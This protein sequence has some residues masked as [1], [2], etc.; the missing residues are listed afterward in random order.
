MHAQAEGVPF[1][2]E[3]LA[4]AYRESGLIQQIDGV[5]TLARERRAA[6]AVRGADAD[7]APRRAPAR[8]DDGAPRRRRDPRPRFSLK[9][10]REVELRVGRRRGTRA[11][12][13]RRR[14]LAPAVAAGLLLE[15]ARG[16]RPPTTA[17]RTSRSASSPPARSRRR[18]AARSTRAIVDLLLDAGSPPPA[19]LPLLAQHALAAGDAARV[20]PLLDRGGRTALAANAPEEVL[21]VVELALPVAASSQERLDLLAT[22]DD[23]LGM[24]RRPSDRLEGLAELAALAEALGDP[25]L[26]LDVQLRRASALRVAEDED[27]AAEL[28]RGSARAPSARATAPPSSRRASSSGRRSCAPRSGESFGPAEREVDLDGAEEAYRRAIELAEEL[29]DEP[30]LAAA[31]REIGVV[32]I[33]R[34]R[35][36]FVEQM[37][38]GAHVPIARASRP[39]RRSRTSSPSSRSRR[40]SSRAR[41]SSSGRSSSSS[42]SATAAA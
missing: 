30:S 10:L 25:H 19:S 17:S 8:R 38:A 28:A 32:S 18:G 2:V 35:A 39:A 13:A 41:S 9:D 15:H 22:R 36:W 26:E 14:C 4:R 33:G 24:L 11:R 6:G 3:E 27:R 42:G 20:R 23:A 40:S 34:V 21:R 7:L 1:I 12:G 37:Q 5:W 29:G 16:I 31:L